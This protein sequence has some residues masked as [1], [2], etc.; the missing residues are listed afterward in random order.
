[1]MKLRDKNGVWGW[2]GANMDS[3]RFED[4]TRA[5]LSTDMVEM[6]WWK[7]Y[8]GMALSEITDVRD[9]EFIRDKAG[10]N[11]DVFASHCASLRLSELNV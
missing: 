7:K 4:G 3:V 11:K 6:D 9:L 2:V 1:M 8:R 5:E 10:E